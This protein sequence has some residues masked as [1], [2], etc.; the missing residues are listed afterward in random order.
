MN[1]DQHCYNTRRCQDLQSSKPGAERSRL[2][3]RYSL[4][5]LLN[6]MNPSIMEA[7]N[8]GSISRMTNI[9]K[10]SSLSEYSDISYCCRPECYACTSTQ[11]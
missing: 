2:S 9:V 11:T 8:T 5:N 7:M 3:I 6:T 1:S 10:S 4:P